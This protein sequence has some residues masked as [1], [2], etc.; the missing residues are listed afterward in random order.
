MSFIQN[1]TRT[2]AHNTTLSRQSYLHLFGLQISPYILPLMYGSMSP[3]FRIL[4]PGIHGTF[5]LAFDIRPARFNGHHLKLCLIS[6]RCRYRAGTRYFR[7][8]IDHDGNVANFNETEQILLVAGSKEDSSSEEGGVQLSFVQIRGS[9][10]VFWGEVNT[11]RYKPD[12]VI[13]EL[14][15]AVSSFLLSQ[16]I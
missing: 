7:R 11:L 5:I 16:Y 3:T 4:L 13:M 9:V 8:G 6:R 2:Y 14:Q 15:D 1:P 10:P 12:V